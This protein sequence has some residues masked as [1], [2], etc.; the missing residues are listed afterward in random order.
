VASVINLC[1]GAALVRAG[2]R[3]RS[4]TLE[5]DGKHLLTDVWTSVGVVVGVAAVAISGWERLDA[6][7][8]LLVAANIVFTGVSLM[9]RSVSG[10]MDAALDEEAHAQIAQVLAGFEQRGVQF[11][12]LRTRQAGQRAF[13]STHVLVPG[14]WSVRQGHDVA[15]EV[16][17]ALRSKVPQATVF[18]HVE[19]A[20]DPRSFEDTALDRPPP[21]A[22]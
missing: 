6:I 5:A 17:A 19:P 18:T 4:I 7:V 3:H 14:S 15:E 16:E 9:R 22:Q 13:I 11:H 12:A 1:V 8:A 21:V 20:D 10:L 2:R